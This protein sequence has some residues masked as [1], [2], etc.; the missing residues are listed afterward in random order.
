M[1]IGKW[2]HAAVTYKNREFVSYVNG[3]KEFT[4]Q[5]DYLPISTEAKTS[6][7]ARMNQVHWF[8]GAIAKVRISKKVLM[9]AECLTLK[10]L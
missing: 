1:L 10:K 6:I 2:A 9:P 7:G 5:V 8:N 4:G 3:Q